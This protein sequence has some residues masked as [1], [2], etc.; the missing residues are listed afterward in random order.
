[1][2]KLFVLFNIAVLLSLCF[3]GCQESS[4]NQGDKNLVE[5]IHYNIKTE[6]SQWD[7]EYKIIS[8]I[9][10]NNAGKTLNSIEVIINFYDSNKS[11]LR[12]KS[13]ILTN[14]PDTNT[15]EF[16]ITYYSSNKYYKEVDWNNIRFD[17]S[18]S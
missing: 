14:I 11:F 8:G 12:S 17:F 4:D 10:K 5:L 13:D 9:V 7:D 2:K 15:G 6:I 1:M 18:V 16:I 3:C